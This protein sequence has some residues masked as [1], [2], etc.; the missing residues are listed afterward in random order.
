MRYGPIRQGGI[1][2]PLRFPKRIINNDR[3][4][5]SFI[6]LIADPFVRMPRI[7]N[8]DVG[9]RP[10]LILALLKRGTSRLN[11]QQLGMSFNQPGT[12]IAMPSL[13]K[14]FELVWLSFLRN[15]RAMSRLC[16]SV[17]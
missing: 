7:D 17:E 1:V 2:C 13:L 11:S 4:G 12:D 9:M 15:S 6:T 14:R 3:F 8:D 16:S 5:V 10:C